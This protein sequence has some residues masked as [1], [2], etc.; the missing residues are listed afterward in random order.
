[1]GVVVGLGQTVDRQMGVFL[2]RGQTRMTQHFLDGPQIGP[3]IEHMRGKRM[4]D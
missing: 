2:R 3:R 4:P 1:M